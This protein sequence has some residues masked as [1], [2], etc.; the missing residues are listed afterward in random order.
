MERRTISVS[1]WYKSPKT[2]KKAALIAQCGCYLLHF[3]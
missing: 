2:T 1:R 3:A